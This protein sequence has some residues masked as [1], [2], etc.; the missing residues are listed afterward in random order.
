M[1]NSRPRRKRCRFCKELFHPDPRLASRQYACSKPSCQK[2]RK[3]TKQKKWFKRNPHYFQGRYPNTKKWL[4]A[5]PGYL[6]QYRCN[7]P[8]A[9]RRDNEKRKFRHRGAKKAYADI[10]V[11]L[12]LQGHIL[13]TLKP[14][15]AP[16]F[17]ADIQVA[18]WKQLIIISMVSVSYLA[19]T[20]ADIQVPIAF[21]K[22][23]RYPG[24]HDCKT[25]PGS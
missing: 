4:E 17:N 11:A 21:S 22:S 1:T 24:R 9:V 6:K 7:H 18:F 12:S 25:N 16:I 5:H 23:P 14:I 19:R 13:K 10:Q 20:R 8:E 2:A 15:L 3:H